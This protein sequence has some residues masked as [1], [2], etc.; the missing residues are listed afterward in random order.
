MGFGRAR[1]SSHTA[2]R[3]ALHDLF[4]AGD[5]RIYPSC[6]TI[7]DIVRVGTFVQKAVDRLLACGDPENG[8]IRLRCPDCAAERALP[9]SCKGRGLCPSCGARRI[10]HLQ[11]S[12]RSGW[13]YVPSD[14][15]RASSPSASEGA[16]HGAPPGGARAARWYQSYQSGVARPDELAFLE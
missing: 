10:P 11:T 16:R 3:D 2:D 6:Q 5:Y 15:R 1:L 8:F 9:F 4:Q 7:L 14:E 13:G 12:L